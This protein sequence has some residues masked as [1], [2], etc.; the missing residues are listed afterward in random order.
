[1]LPMSAA[2]PIFLVWCLLLESHTPKKYCLQHY[3][4]PKHSMMF[5]PEFLRADLGVKLKAPVPGLNEIAVLQCPLHFWL[6]QWL[7]AVKAFQRICCIGR[8][9]VLSF[10][11]LWL[12]LPA[13]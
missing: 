5:Y 9:G 3:L 8:M 4:Q 11:F 1:M 7:V 12:H 13:T 10:R 6:N 2:R